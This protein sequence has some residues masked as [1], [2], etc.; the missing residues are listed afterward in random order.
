MFLANHQNKYFLLLA[1]LNI[2]L[3]PKISLA[4][5]LSNP[6]DSVLE[7]NIDELDPFPESSQLKID[8]QD[9]LDRSKNLQLDQV[10]K[11]INPRQIEIVGNRVFSESELATLINPEQKAVLSPEDLRLTIERIN[12]VYQ[13]NGYITSGVFSEPKLDK[14]GRILIS[15][16]EG[17]I[18]DIKIT[19]LTRL[20][21]S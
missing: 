13:D 21:N 1:L 12:R 16:T 15:I 9:E 17:K 14:N 20:R 3:V 5:T 2:V 11:N 10:P 4:Q 7:T 19:G 8:L 18:E 6:V